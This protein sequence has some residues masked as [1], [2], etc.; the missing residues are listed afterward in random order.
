M[1]SVITAD[2]HLTRR[3]G[4]DYRWKLFEDFLP[5]NPADEFI[6]LGDLTDAKDRHDS[7]LVNRLCEAVRGLSGYGRVIILKGNHDY[8]D[9][10]HPF[11]R[12]LD[13]GYHDVVFISKPTT[14]RLTIG[15][16]FFVPA[17]CNWKEFKIEDDIK[18]V[19]THATFDGAKSENGTLMTGV[20][21]A[22]LAQYSGK[23]YSGDIHAPQ[24]L[25]RGKIEY[26][27]APYHTRFGDQFEPRILCVDDKGRETDLHF[28]APRKLVFQVRCPDDLYACSGH[29]G[30]HVKIRCYLRR[31]EYDK[32]RDYKK[33][34]SVRAERAGYRVFGIDSVLIEQNNADSDLSSVTSAVVP[35]KVFEDY[36]IRNK[37][38]KV[39]MR[40]GRELLGDV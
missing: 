3:P 14:L 33:E 24:K 17:G 20:N 19:M 30:D 29:K 15:Q 26:V 1:A 22:V 18:Y 8:Y 38:S 10:E 4:D 32:W 12:F 6:I 39:F 25:A 16:V 9:S 40:I 34:L 28:D 27:G 21:P 23:C 11:F 35:E 7:V 13:D 31:S 2:I 5:Q 37:T 36:G